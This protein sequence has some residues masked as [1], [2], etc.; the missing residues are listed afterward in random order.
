LTLLSLIG[1]ASAWNKVSVTPSYTSK[2]ALA[3]MVAPICKAT[4]RAFSSLYLVLSLSRYHSSH[5]SAT[6]RLPTTRAS[7]HPFSLSS[8][9]PTLASLVLTVLALI[10][11][12]PHNSFDFKLH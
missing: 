6:P 4:L 3:L 11:T 12:F 9:I 1:I 5:F 8:L 2:F 10:L 7:L